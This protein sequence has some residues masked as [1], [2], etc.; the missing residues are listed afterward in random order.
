MSGSRSWVFN[1]ADNGQEKEDPEK[2]PDDD[3]AFLTASSGESD[4]EEAVDALADSDDDALDAAALRDCLDDHD[5][6]TDKDRL[7][8]DRVAHPPDYNDPNAFPDVFSSFGNLSS[9]NCGPNNPNLKDNKRTYVREKESICSVS[10]KDCDTEKV[11]K[12]SSVPLE[13]ER[14]MGVDQESPSLSNHCDTTERTKGDPESESTLG[15]EW[16]AFSQPK[17]SAND[18]ARP[19]TNDDDSGQTSLKK[20]AG[21][22]KMDHCAEEDEDEEASKAFHGPRMNRSEYHRERFNRWR[23]NPGGDG[24]ERARL[25]KARRERA[26]PGRDREFDVEE[27]EQEVKPEDIKKEKAK[28]DRESYIDEESLA[29]VEKDMTVEDKEANRQLAKQYKAKGNEAFKQGEWQ[30]ALDSYN[31]GLNT[32][33]LMYEDDRSVL[34]ANRAAVWLKRDSEKDKD[35]VVNDCAKALELNPKYLKARLRKAAVLEKM[36]KLEDALEDYKL[37]LEQDPRNREALEACRRLPGE[38][39]EKNEKLKA[40]M[41]SK[42]KDLGNLVLKPFGLSTNNFQMQQDP[43]SG[44]YTINFKQ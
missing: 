23:Q 21:D 30:S 10:E 31:Q 13:D 26:G 28:S 17:Q 12:P 22:V 9:S 29:E 34:Y 19:F 1:D 20:G 16:N 25:D 11:P 6:V 37:V 38:I 42:L 18:F 33:P 39:N 27:A 43:N 14:S 41:M 5:F 2:D 32:C 44:G 4:S 15:A 7:F 40:E 8:L 3:D 24:L 35:R 36:E